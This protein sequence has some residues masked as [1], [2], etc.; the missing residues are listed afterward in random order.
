MMDILF[1]W[2][3]GELVWQV[4]RADGGASDAY[5]LADNQR[6]RQREI[7]VKAIAMLASYLQ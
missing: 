6:E 4:L 3:K 7:A 2:P 5:E 1:G